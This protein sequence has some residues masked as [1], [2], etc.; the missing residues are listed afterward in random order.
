MVAL[1]SVRGA[2][3]FTMECSLTMQQYTH[4]YY[5][6]Q[7]HLCNWASLLLLDTC[8]GFILEYSHGECSKE[9]S[10]CG[11]C[12]TARRVDKIQ[13]IVP[14]VSFHNPAASLEDERYHGQCS[15]GCREKVTTRV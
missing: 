10:C 13:V 15:R 3:K 4:E 9:S 11:M 14:L 12:D 8:K 1:T 7:Q 5:Q 6:S 2:R